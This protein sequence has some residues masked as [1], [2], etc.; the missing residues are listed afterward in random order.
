MMAW[1]AENIVHWS[2]HWVCVCMWIVDWSTVYSINNGSVWIDLVAWKPHAI[3]TMVAHCAQYTQIEVRAIRWEWDQMQA[4]VATIKTKPGLHQFHSFFTI[5]TLYRIRTP[6]H[7]HVD[8][9]LL[10]WSKKRR[11]KKQQGGMNEGPLETVA[12]PFLNGKWKR[13]N[14]YSFSWHVMRNGERILQR[15]NET[16]DSEMKGCI[17]IHNIEFKHQPSR[18]S[19]FTTIQYSLIQPTNGQSYCEI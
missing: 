4:I 14:L 18:Y 9:L 11:R 2:K 8:F 16:V 5:L 7:L 15:C 17:L 12:H 3:C 6:H 10:D 1:C 19:L 13:L